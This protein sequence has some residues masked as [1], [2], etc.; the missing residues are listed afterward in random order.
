L[1]TGAMDNKII[2]WDLTTLEKETEI[3]LAHKNGIF[4]VTFLPN[5]SILSGGGDALIKIFT[6]NT[7]YD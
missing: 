5:G 1:V 3:P 6:T 4:R 7:K 2:V